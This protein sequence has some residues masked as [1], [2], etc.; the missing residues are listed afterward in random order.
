MTRQY[1]SKSMTQKQGRLQ[2]AL[3][4]NSCTDEALERLTPRQVAAS[5]AGVTINEASKALFAEQL[6]RS[7]R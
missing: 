6:R 1:G 5:Y 2:F 3:L 4:L 7:A